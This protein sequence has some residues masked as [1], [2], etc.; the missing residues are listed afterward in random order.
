M[1]ENVRLSLL[2]ILG[3]ILLGTAACNKT[4]QKSEDIK[5]Y[6]DRKDYHSFSN[7][8]QIKVKH[9]VLDI[10]VLFEEKIL[11]GAATLSVE[12]T[13]GQGTEPLILD[14]RDLNISAVE[15]SGD[16]GT[17]FATVQY[18]LG[19]K[20]PILGSPLTIQVPRNV[21][22]V[23]VT[24]STSPGATA[25]Q[26]LTPAQTAG[27]KEPFLYTQSQAI[28]ARS[29]IPIQDSPGVRVTY[30]ARVKT[31]KNLL[32]VMSAKSDRVGKS[33]TGQYGFS[34]Q[35]PIPAYLIA[36]AVGDLEYHGLT[37]R[38]GIYAEPSVLPKASKEFEDMDKL[39]RAAESIYG[40]YQWEQ[41][42]VLVLPPSFPYGGMENPRLTFV[43]PT[44]LAGDKSLVGVIS[45]EMAHS[46]SGNLV[47]N[48]TWRDFWLNEGFTTYFERRIQEEVYGPARAEMEALIEKRQLEDELKTLAPRDQVLYI[49]LK[50]RDPDEGSTLVPYVKGMLLLRLIEK[51]YDRERF[52][53]FLRGYFG[54]NPF[55]SITTGEFI[56][57]LKDHLYKEDESLANKVN[58]EEWLTKPGLPAD[59]PEPQSS[60]LNDVEKLGAAWVAGKQ[61]LAGMPTAKWSA[62]EWQHFPASMPKPLDKGKMAELDKAFNLTKS[63]NAEIKFVWL[64][65][66]IRG[67][68]EAAYPE[69]QSFLIEVGRRKYIR[70]LY[71]E[72]AKTPEGM[73][74]AR[75]IY[76]KAR[77][78]YHPISSE[79]IDQILK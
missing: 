23:R 42:D 78:G 32:A 66:T 46:W 60:A 67:K 37:S 62:A 39:L 19:A 69:L 29:W 73:V 16:G 64:M 31:P 72:L 47:T 10:T 54:Q 8:E 3:G 12:R 21:T 55:Q 75:A 20:D 59:A 48:A 65:M 6:G 11:K 58:L 53:A 4:V 30:N 56:T 17:K 76:A 68:Y 9:L 49:D 1:I 35:Q 13:G 57:Y 15:A 63:G 2:L 34:M 41:Y 18:Q 74:R 7:P 50:G 70:P 52:D 79:T 40:V 25:L 71:Q 33:T 77:P 36:L 27:K 45:H 22:N 28:H 26:W 43:T 24:Y 38:T 44:L 61:P 51:T 14:T 5:R